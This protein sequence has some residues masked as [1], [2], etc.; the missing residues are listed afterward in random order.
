[1]TNLKSENLH[2]VFDV[3]AN[4][5]EWTLQAS[6]IFSKA[7]VYSFEPIPFTFNLL[8]TN[9]APFGQIR[10]FNIALSN[11]NSQV[12]M[13]FYES[14]SIFS[15]MFQSSLVKDEFQS[16]E[17]NCV[18]GDDFCKKFNIELIDFLK[19]DTEG[20][21]FQILL[22]FQEMIKNGRI[23]FIQF[24]YGVFSL[25]TKYLLKDF[26]SFFKSYGYCV[27]KLYPD[28]IDFTDYNY[29]KENFMVANYVAILS[30]ERVLTKLNS[31]R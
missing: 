22:G 13:N 12:S 30:N 8:S 17:V 24:E 6:K 31:N 7:T 21:E 3:G 11:E 1:M 20:S 26:F 5:G 19:I 9:T 23:R 4:I 14:N 25:E 28:F 29:R 15:S 27:G 16:V 10:K 2:T 18:K